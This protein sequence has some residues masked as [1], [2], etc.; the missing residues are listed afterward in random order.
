MKLWYNKNISNTLTVS[1]IIRTTVR[2]KTLF[3]LNLH[4]FKVFCSNY[5]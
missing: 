4:N 3:D 1:G 5:E 2:K